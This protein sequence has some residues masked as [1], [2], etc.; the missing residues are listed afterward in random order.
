MIY[1]HYVQIEEERGE[2]I[3]DILG[4]D[5]KAEMK[6]EGTRFWALQSA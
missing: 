2:D 6:L 1:I 3:N 5:K 4:T